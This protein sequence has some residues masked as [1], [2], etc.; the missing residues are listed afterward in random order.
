MMN[1][2]NLCEVMWQPNDWLFAY[3]VG[4]FS[5]FANYISTHLA[6]AKLAGKI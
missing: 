5:V 2:L 3:F 6:K 1:L 4:E